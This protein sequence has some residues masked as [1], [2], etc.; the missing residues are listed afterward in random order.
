MYLPFSKTP[1]FE[2]TVKKDANVQEV[3][4]YTLFEY[5]NQGLEPSIP[6]NMIDTSLWSI[7]I[8]EDDGTIDADFPG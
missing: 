4:G 5:V 6:K 7:R 2:I 3:I 8:A 1:K